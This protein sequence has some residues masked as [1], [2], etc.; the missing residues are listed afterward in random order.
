MYRLFFM[1]TIFLTTVSKAFSTGTTQN[2]HQVT[3]E[4]IQKAENSVYPFSKL[5]N[6]INRSVCPRGNFRGFNIS[7]LP[8]IWNP[9]VAFDEIN[10]PTFLFAKFKDYSEIKSSRPETNGYLY[11]EFQMRNDRIVSLYENE[12]GGSPSFKEIVDQCT[13]GMLGIRKVKM[14][15]TKSPVLNR[16]LSRFGLEEPVKG[17]VKDYNKRNY[18]YWDFYRQL[19]IEESGM[20]TNLSQGGAVFMPGCK[21]H[22]MSLITFLERFPF[23]EDS[24]LVADWDYGGAEENGPTRDKGHVDIK[25]NPLWLLKYKPWGPYYEQINGNIYRDLLNKIL[26]DN[27]DLWE[28]VT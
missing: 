14:D 13:L 18:F 15:N 24:P 22:R 20:S 5:E 9:I 25:L 7:S 16:E 26:F 1:T 11:R 17:N 21:M 12:P 2:T 23:N 19:E 27:S 28:D 4:I 3:R 10:G 8:K 6:D